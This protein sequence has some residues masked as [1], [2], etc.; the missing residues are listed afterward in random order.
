MRCDSCCRDNCSVLYRVSCIHKYNS[1]E[2]KILCSIC[3][4]EAK[5]SC[6]KS[7]NGILQYEQLSEEELALIILGRF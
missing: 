3:L 1:Y 4:S 7:Y 6:R 5:N 2:N